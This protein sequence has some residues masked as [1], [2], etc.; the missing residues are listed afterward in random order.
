LPAAPADRFSGE[1]LRYRVLADG[2]VVYSV[3]PDGADDL[4]DTQKDV[5]FRVTQ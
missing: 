3:G 4:G 1:P 5:A 2:F